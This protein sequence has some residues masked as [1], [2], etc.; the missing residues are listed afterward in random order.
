MDKLVSDVG[1]D[2]DPLN[3][4][5]DISSQS[6]QNKLE[7]PIDLGDDNVPCTVEGTDR[8]EA[9]GVYITLW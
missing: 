4:F 1:C 2:K 6:E 7:G 8:C 5:D 3:V 9:R